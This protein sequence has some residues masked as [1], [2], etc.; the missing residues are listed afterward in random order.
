MKR[1]AS[2]RS[3]LDPLGEEAAYQRSMRRRRI[4]GRVLVGFLALVVLAGAVAAAGIHNILSKVR[5]QPS[6]DTVIGA[7]AR[8]SKAPPPAS[9]GSPE[10]IL[11]LGV[12]SRLGENSSFQPTTGPAQTETLSD[13]AIL[14]HLSADGKHV[15][16]VS[17]PRD[18]VVNIPSCRRV[19]A[20]GQ[21]LSDSAGNPLYTKPVQ[22]LFNEAIQLGGPA[23]SVKTL[24]TL[25]GIY[26]DHYLEIDFEGVIKMSNAL[27]GVPLTICSPIHDAHTGLNLPAGPVLLKG[28]QAL[29]FVR[30]RYGLTGGDDLHRIQRQQQFMAAMVRKALST[31][32]FFDPVHMYEFYSA[33]AGSITT[34]MSS[35]QLINLAM[36]YRHINTQNIVFA[37]VPTYPA[38]KGDKWYYHLYWSTDEADL[39]FRY[40][41]D[42]QPLNA[43]PSGGHNVATITVPPSEVTVEVLNGTATNGLARQVAD[44]LAAEGFRIAGVGNASS[45]PVAKTTISYPASRTDSMKTLA[46]ALAVTPQETL[47]TSASNVLVLT[48]GTDWAGLAASSPT[49]SPALSAS[50][51]SPSATPSLGPLGVPTTNAADTQCVQG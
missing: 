14:V 35:S 13:T 33:V 9:G 10:N 20:N 44:Q 36:R 29:A 24:E 6:L 23:C 18:S 5:H 46:G 43:T 30:A 51:G 3:L 7:T 41:R 32:N 40:I 21:P 38:P 45:I 15:T 26:I 8:P 37:T 12:D 31:S 27:G 1:P 16:L 11:V 22:A 25:T 47:D 17:I 42:D 19:D 28:Q 39:L 50:P 49:P 48:I 4:A 34:D 2:P